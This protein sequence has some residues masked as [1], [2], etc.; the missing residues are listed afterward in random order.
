MNWDLKNMPKQE[1]FELF[2]NDEELAKKL[3]K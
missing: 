3:K 1:L 2:Y